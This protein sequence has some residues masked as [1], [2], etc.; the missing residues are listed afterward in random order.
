MDANVLLI[1]RWAA[2]VTCQSYP[3]STRCTDSSVAIF[4]NAAEASPH[5]S[6]STQ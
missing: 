5:G 6:I 3:R 4:L 1:K 2:V